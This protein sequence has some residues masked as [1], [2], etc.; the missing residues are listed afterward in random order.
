MAIHKI[1][2]S[3]VSDR[4]DRLLLLSNVNATVYDE[5]CDCECIVNSEIAKGH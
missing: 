1:K 3:L 2:L 5:G 4:S